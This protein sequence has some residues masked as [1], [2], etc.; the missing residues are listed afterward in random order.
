MAGI[1]KNSTGYTK[2][3][4]PE[5]E[6]LALGFKKIKFAHQANAGD[7]GISFASLTTPAIMLGNG[8]VQPNFSALLGANLGVYQNNLALTSSARG[9]LELDFDFTIGS[10][11]QINFVEFTA[12][13]NEVFVGT[14]D[15]VSLIGNLV[16]DGTAQP[17]TGPLL[18]G[19]TTFNV[20]LPFEINLYPNFQVGSVMVYRNGRLQV[21]NAGNSPTGVGNYYEQPVAGGFGS[22]VI[23]NI[24]GVLLADGSN[25]QIVVVPNGFLVERPQNSI[26]ATI[27]NLQGQVDSLVPTVASLAGVP[28]TSFQIAPNNPDLNQFG[29][30]F[31]ALQAAVALI[32]PI[33][34]KYSGSSLSLG[35]GGSGALLCPD[36]EYDTTGGGYNPTTGTFTV[37]PGGTG[38]WLVGGAFAGEALTATV[39]QSFTLIANHNT[40]STSQ[41]GIFEMTGA[42]P[43][44]VYP[45]CV[46]GSAPIPAQAGDQLAV[47]I[48]NGFGVT[49]TSNG[50]NYGNYVWFHKIG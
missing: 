35:T 33:G 15:P 27:Q 12:L 21:R 23:F 20:G 36:V 41:I 1:G 29:N 40:S 9:P 26:L 11:T 14:I 34:V 13:Q 39:S 8:F 5:S 49:L 17:S 43:N 4:Y 46:G 37:P 50:V 42:G 18:P 31:L 44:G 16:V 47:E 7:T 45:A 28:T 3:D 48:I 32:T 2:V 22:L 19:Q 25:E 6:T 24:P 30:A 10:P 38:I